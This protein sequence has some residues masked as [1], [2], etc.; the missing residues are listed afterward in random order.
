LQ[1]QSLKQRNY[2]AIPRVQSFGLG[3]HH[4]IGRHLAQLEVRTL[5]HEFLSRVNDFEFAVHEA[6][7]NQ[8]YFQRG[9]ISLPVIIRD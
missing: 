6:G 2:D 7:L 1:D 5:A 8:G 9:W 3:Q 4:C